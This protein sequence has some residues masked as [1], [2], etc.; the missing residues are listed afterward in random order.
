MITS[1]PEAPPDRWLSLIRLGIVG[2]VTLILKAFEYVHL[3][4]FCFVMCS[5]TLCLFDLSIPGG[6]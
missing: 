2:C 3:I 1:G 6:W 5:W 4:L